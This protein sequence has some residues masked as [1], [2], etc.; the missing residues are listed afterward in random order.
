MT[1]SLTA[2]CVSFRCRPE[3]IGQGMR[4]EG[5]HFEGINAVFA[6]TLQKVFTGLIKRPSDC[7]ESLW[8][9]RGCA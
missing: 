3:S 4:A 5:L 1:V 9:W 6:A 7:S 2:F 8:H